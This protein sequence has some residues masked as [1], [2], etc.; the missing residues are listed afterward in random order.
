MAG[1]RTSFYDV[2]SKQFLAKVA[3]IN[4]KL[5]DAKKAQ[6]EEKA[7]PVPVMQTDITA[8][9]L[10]SDALAMAVHVGSSW[11]DGEVLQSAVEK[12]NA[13]VTGANETEGDGHR[14]DSRMEMVADNIRNEFGAA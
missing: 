14:P 2:S 3:A 1:A 9:K 8:R 11:M 12:Y 6:R 7:A 5:D 4:S 10:Y 13:E